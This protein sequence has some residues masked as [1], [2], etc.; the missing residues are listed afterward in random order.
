[1]EILDTKYDKADL[2]SIAKN[3]CLHLS[4][5]HRNSLFA[6]LLKFKELFDGMRS[7]TGSYRLSPLN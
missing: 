6:L 1:M 2:P 4:T 3:N 5:S 7:G